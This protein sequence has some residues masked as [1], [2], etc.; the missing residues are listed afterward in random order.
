MKNTERNP[1][2]TYKITGTIT[3][4]GAE[5]LARGE[6]VMN[7]RPQPQIKFLRTEKRHTKMT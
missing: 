5:A 6:K 3:L 2:A 4:Y 7:K 1:T